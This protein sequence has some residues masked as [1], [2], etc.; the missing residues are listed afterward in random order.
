MQIRMANTNLHIWFFLSITKS[1][2]VAAETLKLD[3]VY[4]VYPGNKIFT[5]ESNI[6]AIGLAAMTKFG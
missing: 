5:L 3:E 4:I 2:R 1:V 6:I